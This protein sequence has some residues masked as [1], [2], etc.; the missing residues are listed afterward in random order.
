MPSA[1]AFSAKQRGRDRIGDFRSARLAHRRDVI[2]VD[3]QTN[4][5]LPADLRADL[6][7]RYPRAMARIFFSSSPSNMTRASNSVP[8]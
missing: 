7:R 3:S 6:D 5:V 4:H 2:D 8:E 1:P